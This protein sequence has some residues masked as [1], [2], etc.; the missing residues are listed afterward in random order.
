MAQLIIPRG[1]IKK[2]DNEIK[3]IIENIVDKAMGASAKDVFFDLGDKLAK[4]IANSKEFLALKTTLRGAFG[5]TDEEISNL[6][7]A[8][9]LLEPFA[10]NNI[11][12]INAKLSGKNKSII[13]EW[14]DFEKLKNH[15]FAQH[16]LTKFNRA[17]GQFDILTARISWIEWLED[18]ATV[19]GYTLQEPISAQSE[20]FSRSGLALMRKQ[21]GG[22]WIF[23]PTSI[24]KRTAKQLNAE[25]VIKKGFGVL[26]RKT[27]RAVLKR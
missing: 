21:P 3:R 20:Q 5:F 15:P 26:L 24:F 18:G 11:S 17:T 6:D 7:K 27:A 19:R 13:L 10:G 8:I 2:F 9:K 12:K 14:V 23:E 4:Q 16:D 22:F 25:K 1:S